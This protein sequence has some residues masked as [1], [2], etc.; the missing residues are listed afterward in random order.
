MSTICRTADFAVQAGMLDVFKF[1]AIVAASGTGGQF[2]IVDAEQRWR[3]G[4]GSDAV[5]GVRLCGNDTLTD[6]DAAFTSLMQISRD[7]ARL[8]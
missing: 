1:D 6:F 8:V 2:E 7:Y 4:G 5:V 3:P